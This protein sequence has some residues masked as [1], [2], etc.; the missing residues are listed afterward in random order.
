MKKLVIAAAIVCAAAVSQAA[1]MSWATDMITDP[2]TKEYCMG[3]GYVN[4]Y[5]FSIDSIQYDAL[6]KGVADADISAKVW[7]AYKGQLGSADVTQPD[8]GNMMFSLLDPNTY[9]KDETAYAV[10]V[11]TYDKGEGK[12]IEYYKGNVGSYNFEA[13][14][15]G[16]LPSMDSIVFGGNGTT[17][18]D[19]SVNS[20]PE[21]TSGLLLLLG[22]AGL[23]L[24][25]RRA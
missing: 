11:M 10:F 7:D 17:A 1:T 16:S 24:R 9:G 13:D 21:P 19:W 15:A 23:A 14:V 12:G 3:E 2:V 5:L 4:M 8:D 6:T 20:V 25:R 18:L 22:V